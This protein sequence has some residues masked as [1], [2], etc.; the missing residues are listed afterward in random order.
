MALSARIVPVDRLLVAYNGLLALLW[1]AC[2]GTT[3][4]AIWLFGAHVVGIAAPWLLGSRLRTYADRTRGRLGHAL[5]AGTE[6]YPLVLVILFWTELDRL[7]PALGLESYDGPI[8]GLDRM[9]FGREIHAVWQ[10]SMDALWFSELMYFMYFIYFAAVFVPPLVVAL[11]GRFEATREMVL[12]LSVAYLG[13]YAAFALMPVDGPHY[14]GTFHTGANA[15]GFFYGLVGYV[16][17]HGDS[18]GCSFPS[19]HVVGAVSI[20][21]LAWRWLP[22]PVAGLLS[23]EALGVVLSTV[24]TQNHYA[25]DS[26][27]GIGWALLAQV[28]LVPLVAGRPVLSSK[29]VRRPLRETNR[30]A[31][32]TDRVRVRSDSVG[33]PTL[34]TGGTGFIGR[35]LVRRLTA[36]GTPV[37]VL[38]RDPERARRLLP[39]AAE[40]VPGD[41][42]ERSSVASALHGVDSVVHA[43]AVARAWCRDEE[44][45]HRV[46]VSAVADL[47]EEARRHDVR[48]LVHVSTILTLP[49]HAPASVNGPCRRPTPYEVT[50][51]AGERLA[52]SAAESG[53]PVII[54]HPTRVYGPGPLHDANAVTRLIDQYVRGR[55][56]LR[57]ADQDVLANYVH[58][59]DVAA[60]IALALRHGRAGA[61]YVLGGAE[62]VSFRSLLEHVTRLSGVRRRVLAIPPG[63]VIVCARLAERLGRLGIPLPLTPGWVRIF[64]E[65]R[66]AD[67]ESARLDLGYAPRSL[68]EG[69]AGTLAWLE[70]SG[71]GRSR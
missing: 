6:L 31:P 38:A 33:P 17:Q 35:Y 48:R 65:D 46:N 11:R 18:L 32:A 19:S 28:A 8:S 26:L 71:E 52:S 15:A 22:R 47:L 55:F 1:L 30:E 36:G 29:A 4:A 42:T 41:I 67:I 20:A 70:R 3:D 59:D 66:R 45:F 53:L 60:G 12:G 9:I 44:E 7:R 27:A 13:C 49:P 5:R 57:L 56:R 2:V 54:V 14:L 21:I 50:K 40:V 62:N 58:A 39:A 63:P 16:E 61:H 23:V 68:D 64:L 25:V 37:R 69:L 51:L 34:I 24:Y 10:P 43:A